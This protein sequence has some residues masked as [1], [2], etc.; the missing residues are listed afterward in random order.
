MAIMDIKAKL[1]EENKDKEVLILKSTDKKIN[2]NLNQLNKKG[3]Y[4]IIENYEI[5]ET[6]DLFYIYRHKNF[7]N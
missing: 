1:L 3:Y 6:T 4:Y 5:V 7:T 2:N